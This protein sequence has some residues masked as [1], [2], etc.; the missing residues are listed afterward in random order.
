MGLGIQA[1]NGVGGIF[2]F[3]IS[4]RCRGAQQDFRTQVETGSAITRKY[5]SVLRGD[6][7]TGE[8]NSVR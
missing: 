6:D 7:S 3:I 5:P 1:T 4:W 2:N 8:F